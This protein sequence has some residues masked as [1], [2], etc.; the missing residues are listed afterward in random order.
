M[1]T[2]SEDVPS[3]DGALAR[4]ASTAS[5]LVDPPVLCAMPAS[6]RRR[7]AAGATAMFGAFSYPVARSA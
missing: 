5:L 1:D 3:V 7:V 4:E 2:V 6:L